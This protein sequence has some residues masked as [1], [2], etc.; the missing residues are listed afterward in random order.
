MRFRPNIA[1]NWILRHD[2]APTH[3]A[4]SVAQI[5]TS[6]RI[7]VLPQ[8]PYSPDLTSCDFF[9]FQKVKSVVKGHRFKSTEGFRGL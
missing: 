5:L 6:K 7:A 1:E 4:L 9:L 8:S 3:T 2:N